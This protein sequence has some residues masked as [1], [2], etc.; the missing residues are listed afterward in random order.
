MSRI[1]IVGGSLGGLR[2]AEALLAKGWEGGIVVI[3]AERHP[4]YTRPPLSK[5]LL[6]AAP[7]IAA[8]ELRRRPETD[9]VDWRFG[10]SAVHADLEARRLTLSDRS[11][12]AYDG[13]VAATGVRP[14]RLPERVTR[15]GFT[16]RTLDDCTALRPSLSQGTRLAIVGAGFI[17]CE[18]A[19][20]ASALGCGV[21]V[22]ALDRAPMVMPL[23]EVVGAA[24][25]RRHEAR[26][27][28]FHLGRSVRTVDSSASG[29]ILSL[30]DGSR[31]E[32]D[33]FVEAIGSQPCVEWLEGNGLDLTDGV[34]CDNSMRM[35]GRSG[36]VAVGDVARF[37]NPLFDDVPRRVE[38]WQMATETAAR[39]AA[40]L[41]ADLSGTPAETKPFRPLPWFWSDQ[42][43][44]KLQSFGSPALG[45]RAE[46]LEGDLAGE[47]AI[48]YHRGKQLVG[49][50]LLGMP[51]A[52]PRLRREILDSLSLEPA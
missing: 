26:G 50:V 48:G 8:V 23:G 3:S 5:G 52:A 42:F 20:T 18:I 17:G 22:I 33:V 11:V 46:V 34:E 6:A 47:A 40:T 9:A 7:D 39:A 4:P 31:V 30:D 12:I 35:G 1:V 21:D 37:P 10:V 28:K 38:H 32:C 41:L 19:A 36:A 43:E 2:A 45:E 44:T 49:V 15:N 14:R 51:K 24:V 13:I 16:V 25:Q 27:V 29:H